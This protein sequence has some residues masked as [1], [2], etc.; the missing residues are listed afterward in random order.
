MGDSGG[1][2]NQRNHGPL[3]DLF[4][5]AHPCHSLDSIHFRNSLACRGAMSSLENHGLHPWGSRQ[6]RTARTRS[7]FTPNLAMLRAR[8]TLWI[9]STLATP[10]CVRQRCH[11]WITTGCTPGEGCIPGDCASVAQHEQGQISRRQRLLRPACQSV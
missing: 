7:D 5:V 6:C 8:A 11:P 3:S 10:W 2:S 4:N 1:K 9:Q